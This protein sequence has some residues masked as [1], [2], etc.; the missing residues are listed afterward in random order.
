M[1]FVQIK[2]SLGE[3][4]RVVWSECSSRLKTCWSM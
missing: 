4:I 2:S 1:H 3:L